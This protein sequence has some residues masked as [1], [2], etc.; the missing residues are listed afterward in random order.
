MCSGKTIHR[1]EVLE[2]LD[3]R[4]GCGSRIILAEALTKALLTLLAL[5]GCE[6]R[7]EM[8]ERL[9]TSSAAPTSVT[10]FPS[11]S[12]NSPFC[13]PSFKMGAVW[14]SYCGLV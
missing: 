3:L 9:G 11:S 5:R 12:R 2:D 10:L 1:T 8:N 6:T 13:S 14:K 4:D 7:Q